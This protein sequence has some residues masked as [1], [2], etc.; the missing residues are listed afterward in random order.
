MEKKEKEKSDG[1]EGGVEDVVGSRW[2][3]LVDHGQPSMAL[4]F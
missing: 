2:M 1:M 4:L 3:C